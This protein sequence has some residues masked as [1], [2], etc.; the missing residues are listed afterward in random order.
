MSRVTLKITAP[1]AVGAK[2]RIRS[3]AK[4]EFWGEILENF[5][6]AQVGKG[7]DGTPPVVRD[8]YEITIQLDMAD[9]SFYQEHNCGNLGL[10]DGILL[11]VLRKIEAGD[12][13]DVSEERQ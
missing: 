2:P 3:D 10:R 13:V 5:L 1:M 8:E 4:P 9:D 11:D 7:R 6:L 12:V